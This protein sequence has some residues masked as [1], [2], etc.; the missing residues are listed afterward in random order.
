MAKFSALKLFTSLA[1]RIFVNSSNRQIGI[2][3]LYNKI[4]FYVIYL[5]STY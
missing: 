2:V 3:G 5:V 1:K 4:D